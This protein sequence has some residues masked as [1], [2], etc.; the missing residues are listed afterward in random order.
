MSHIPESQVPRP[1]ETQTLRFKKV[2]TIEVGEDGVERQV[3]D[4]IAS[5]DQA[6]DEL[7][8]TFRPLSGS[9][10]NFVVGGNKR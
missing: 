5:L 1:P 2:Y 6:Q 10:L 7:A 9:I 8:K 3:Y 4:P